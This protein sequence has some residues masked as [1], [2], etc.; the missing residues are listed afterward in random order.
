MTVKIGSCAR[1]FSTIIKQGDGLWDHSRIIGVK[2]R[3]ALT[4]QWALRGIHQKDHFIKLTNHIS[5]NTFEMTPAE[6]KKAKGL[7]LCDSLRDH[8]SEHELSLIQLAEVSTLELITHMNPQGF[9]Q[10]FV[11]AGY[12]GEVAG[13]ARRVFEKKAGI[14]ICDYTPKKLT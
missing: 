12:G 8:M 11:V 9:E 1:L 13:V 6:M 7:N 5:L 10:N 4:N 14:K 3:Q 2:I